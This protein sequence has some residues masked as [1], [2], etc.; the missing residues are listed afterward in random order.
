MRLGVADHLGWAVAVTAS[1]DH[2]V[3]DRRRIDLVEPGLPAAPMHHVGGPHQLHRQG[4]PLDDTALAALVAEVR[5]SASRATAA[6]LD[7]LA[8]AVPGPILSVSLRDWP[9]DFPD[10]IAVQRKVPYESRAD[11]IMYRQVLAGLAAIS[12]GRSTSTTRGTLRS[13]RLAFSATERMMCSMDRARRWAPRG[14]RTTGWRWR[15]R[16]PLHD[17]PSPV[18][19]LTVE[20][21]FGS[22]GRSPIFQRG[23]WPSVTVVVCDCPFRS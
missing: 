11:P 10:D 12:V 20:R 19:P 22:T 15:R 9:A 3:V 21:I 1:A 4:E 5:A 17:L 14:R 16:S 7:E 6:A 2:Q 13:R 23:C 18:T 8:T